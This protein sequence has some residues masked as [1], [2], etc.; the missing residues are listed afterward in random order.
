MIVARA[1]SSTI[2]DLKEED[3]DEEEDSFEADLIL[4]NWYEQ[5]GK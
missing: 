5:D 2:I 3:M 1:L 4:T